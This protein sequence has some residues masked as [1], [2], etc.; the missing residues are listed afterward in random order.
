MRVILASLAFACACTSAP[1]HSGEYFTIIR[2]NGDTAQI[3][4]DFSGPFMVETNS[5]S[6][7]SGVAGAAFCA[8]AAEA[9]S[10]A[11]TGS[12]T[13]VAESVSFW[14]TLALD[15]GDEIVAAEAKSKQAAIY[16]KGGDRAL[17]VTNPAATNYTNAGC[18]SEIVKKAFVAKFAPDLSWAGGSE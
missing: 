7:A 10:G 4:V 8:A 14:N 3:P 11:E 12:E 17:G 6:L 2:E 9:Y 1:S 16:E 13:S 5:I 18:S 15:A